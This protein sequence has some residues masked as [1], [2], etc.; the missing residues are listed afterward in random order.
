MR[1][2][3]YIIIYNDKK[4][5]LIINIKELDFIHFSTVL[6]SFNLYLTSIGTNIPI[7]KRSVGSLIS[8]YTETVFVFIRY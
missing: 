5:T 8:Y 4:N 1:V 7:Y 2:K 3:K 6:I